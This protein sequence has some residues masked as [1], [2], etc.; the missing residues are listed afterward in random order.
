MPALQWT[1][2]E[3]LFA[4]PMVSVLFTDI[5]RTAELGWIVKFGAEGLA[6][7][8]FAKHMD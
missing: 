7:F 5:S 6:V 2:S 8:G 3:V 4:V 1:L